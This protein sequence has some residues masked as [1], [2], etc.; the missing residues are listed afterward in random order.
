VDMA[1][2]RVAQ[3]AGHLNYPQGM[4]A[5]QVAIITGSGQGI[6]AETARLFANEGA[7]VVVSDIDG[8]K[9]KDVANGINKS[10]GSAISVP[11]DM[12]DANYLKTLVEKTAEFG[13]GKIHI[14]VNN[15][16]YTWDGV[17]HKVNLLQYTMGLRYLAD[18]EMLDL[19]L[20]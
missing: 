4:L 7:K 8:D 9:A 14:I 5:G 19:N 6:G 2:K 1:D 16:G 18:W 11:G 15:A 17:I 3:I 12:L 13:N 10:G 20:P